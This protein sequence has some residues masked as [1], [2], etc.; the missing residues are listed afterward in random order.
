MSLGVFN[1]TVYGL[2]ANS[3]KGVNNKGMTAYVVKG[4]MLDRFINS[5]FAKPI[6]KVVYL[7][8]QSDNSVTN[9][10]IDTLIRALMEYYKTGR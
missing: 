6:D 5:L 9:H 2:N 4:D 8:Q 1:P 3:Y 7:P 10:L